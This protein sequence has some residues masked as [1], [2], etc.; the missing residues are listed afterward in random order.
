MLIAHK[1]KF[2]LLH[3]GKCAGVSIRQSLNS[4]TDEDKIEIAINHPTLAEC[5]EIIRQSNYDPEEYMIVAMVR[6]PFD[7]M[8]SW[9]Y[10]SLYKAKSF[11]GSFEDF[12]DD[13]LSVA[14]ENLI[15]PY[16]KCNHIIRFENLQ[17][18]F[19][20][21]LDALGFPSHNLPHKN[22]SMSKGKKHYSTLYTKKTKEITANYFASVIEMFNYEFED[23]KC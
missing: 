11:S 15:P 9:Y 17:G 7:R 22:K 14:S 16:D 18:D 20:K 23:K 1:H 6:N 2:I 10:H 13:R 5:Q 8:V 4:I 19:N 3:A 21:F 12:C